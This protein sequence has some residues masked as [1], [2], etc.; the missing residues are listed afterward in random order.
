MKKMVKET[1]EKP[2]TNRHVLATPGPGRPKG[3]K[4]RFTSLKESFLSVFKKL[5]GTDA[6]YKWANKNDHNKGIFY[7]WITK[8]LPANLDIA[9]DILV[10][11]K[12][13]ISDE[14]PKENADSGD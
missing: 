6:L 12:K 7:G 13:V 11:V 9:A 10:T 2:K 1:K 5:G 8:M 14:R 3:C 4:N